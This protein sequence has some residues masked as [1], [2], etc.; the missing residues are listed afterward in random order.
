MADSSPLTTGESTPPTP[1]IVIADDPIFRLGLVTA[2]GALTRFRVAIETDRATV[3]DRGVTVQ[4]EPLP[5]AIVD[6]GADFAWLEALLDVIS[7]SQVLLLTTLNAT[8]RATAARLGYRFYCPKGATIDAIA[9]VLL[10]MR[11]GQFV[12]R[13]PE[14]PRQSPILAPSPNFPQ[15]P[16][17]W[18]YNLRRSGLWQIETS[19]AE[20][21]A[22]LARQGVNWRDRWF[23][24]GRARELR[25][26]RWLV[27]QLLP[28]QIILAP[29]GETPATPEIATE[30]SAIATTAELA[31]EAPSLAEQILQAFLQRAQQ[32]MANA[33]PWMME[34]DILQESRRREL[35]YLIIEELRRWRDQAEFVQPETEEERGAIAAEL[36]QRV[37]REWLRR[38][39][40]ANPDANG[41]LTLGEKAKTVMAL[42]A[43][44]FA[45][46]LFAYLLNESPLVIDQVPYR[47]ESPEAQER[48]GLLLDHLVIQL[49][50]GVMEYLLN[51]YPEEETVKQRLYE[52]EFFTTRSMARFRNELS[53]RSRQFTYFLEPKAIFE[54]RYRLW[55]LRDGQ[56]VRYQLYA[57][58]LDELRE[59]QGIPWLVTILLETRD[60]LA[61]RLRSLLDFVGQGV[62]YVLTKVIGRGLGLIGR[63]IAQGLDNMTHNPPYGR[64]G[65]D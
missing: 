32:G 62:V 26:A 49:A 4:T 10:Q 30:A 55:R 1:L 13:P 14:R 2:L 39:Y 42:G 46:D 29:V 38:Y 60:A 16:P 23:W 58:R 15:Q 8:E 47:P 57:P 56:I 41:G 33:T 5:I 25:L 20:I 43:I 59:L 28:V 9:A 24:Q 53:W 22:I 48:A 11:E 34:I 31:A 37:T 61:P 44:P 7:P 52:P 27:D 50:N 45:T 63:G 64:K 40:P 12:A 35:I 36:W 51:E 19:L 6:S 3:A 17:P 65:N 21:E 54:S 18:L